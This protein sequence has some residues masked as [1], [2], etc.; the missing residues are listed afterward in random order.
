MSRVH[1]SILILIA[2]SQAFKAEWS[3]SRLNRN[4]LYKSNR[5]FPNYANLISNGTS[6]FEDCSSLEDITVIDSGDYLDS[7][8]QVTRNV[9]KSGRYGPIVVN[10]ECLIVITPTWPFGA[11]YDSFIAKSG[12]DL[13]E[14][15]IALTRETWNL[16]LFKK[17]TSFCVINCKLTK[18]ERTISLFFRCLYSGLSK[19]RVLQLYEIIK[20]FMTN[21]VKN[22]ISLYSA[23]KRL[24]KDFK[25]ES[26]LLAAKKREEQL[27]KKINCLLYTS[28][29]PRD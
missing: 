13:G 26:K 27:D 16:P 10:K 14:I 2:F 20:S 17:K 29:S 8:D 5:L 15:R 11:Y 3:F 24:L 18:K 12:N 9:I 28:P 21:Q 23:R 19:K 1:P 7:V 6:S 4:I 22:D 25:D